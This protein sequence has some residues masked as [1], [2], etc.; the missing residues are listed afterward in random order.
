MTIRVIGTVAALRVGNADVFVRR[1]EL[2]PDG[3]DRATVA[4]LVDV[5]L[6]EVVKNRKPTPQVGRQSK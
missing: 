6:V 1:G 4:H 5:G 3:V 2:L